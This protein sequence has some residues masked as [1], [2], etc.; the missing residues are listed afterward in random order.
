MSINT[1]MLSKLIYT[2]SRAI[3][4]A[5]VLSDKRGVGIEIET[6]KS[7][8]NHRSEVTSDVTKAIARNSAS[9]L[10]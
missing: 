7:S 6:P 2:G 9:A 10:E 4:I 5:P 8:S 3:L 1:N